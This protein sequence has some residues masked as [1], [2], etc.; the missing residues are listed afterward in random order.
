[1]CHEPG[2]SGFTSSTLSQV[3][4]TLLN[5][6]FH[7]RSTSPKSIFFESPA[8]LSTYN[9]QVTDNIFRFSSTKL[10][11][12]FLGMFSGMERTTNKDNMK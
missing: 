4:G 5:V 7:S 9:M 3:I 1:M 12:Y 2:K 10:Q 6:K 8:A 11:I